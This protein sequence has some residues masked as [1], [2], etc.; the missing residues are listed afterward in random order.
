MIRLEELRSIPST[1]VFFIELVML[2]N[3]KKIA[4]TELQS[5]SKLLSTFAASASHFSLATALLSLDLPNYGPFE[6]IMTVLHNKQSKFPP[7]F[8]TYLNA[9]P[10]LFSLNQTPLSS[11]FGQDSLLSRQSLQGSV[12]LGKVNT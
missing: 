2:N 4:E 3:D 11:D 5:L 7:G 9:G 8:E 12:G 10:Q 6:D 1:T